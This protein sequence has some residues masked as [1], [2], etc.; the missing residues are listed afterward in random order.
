[1]NP[2]IGADEYLLGLLVGADEEKRSQLKRQNPRSFRDAFTPPASSNIFPNE[3]IESRIT[4]L[5]FNKSI[6]RRFDLSWESNF[7]GKVGIIF[8]E[9]GRFV[10][11]Y[12]PENNELNRWRVI[13]GIQQP[14]NTTRFIASADTFKLDNPTGNRYSKGGIGLRLRRDQ[15]V[16][17]DDKLVSKWKTS[18]QV[19]YYSHKPDTVNEFCEDMLKLCVLY[20]SLAYNENNL[21]NV[22]E[23]F[24]KHGFDGYLLYP[25]DQNNAEKTVAGYFANM[26]TKQE[27]FNLIRDDLNMHAERAELEELLVECISILGV[28]D[29]TNFDAFSAYMGCMLGDKELNSSQRSNTVDSQ[30]NI[31]EFFKVRT[32]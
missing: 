10:A 5:R 25:L 13:N 8:K 18:K 24:I 11:S 20:G 26:T 30:F 29:V 14:E 12:I 3:R 19:V 15:S 1:M 17:T 21:N 32:Y 4:E 23:Y 9:E 22:N 27:G 28:S 2:N 16:D 7:G 31:S 6:T